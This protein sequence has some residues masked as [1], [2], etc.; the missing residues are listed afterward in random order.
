MKKARFTAAVALALAG[1][2]MAQA[3][4]VY[5]LD[6]RASPNRLLSFPSNA[7][8]NNQVATVAVDSFAMDFDALGTTLYAITPGAAPFNLGTI[9][10]TTGAYTAGPAVTGIA[11]GETP[12]GLKYDPQT[13]GW[14]VSANG[15]AGNRLYTLDVNTGVATFATGITGLAA[16]AILIDIAVDLNG[17]MYGHEIAS[18]SL[19]S[20]NK[21]TGVATTIG[22]TGQAANFAQGMDFDYDTNELFA[23]VYTGGGTGVYAK[24]NLT[25][26]LAQVIT[27]TTPWNSEMEMAVN[28]P[29][30]EPASL[31]LLGL[32]ALLLRRR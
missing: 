25:T 9:N 28:A 17:N 16:G 6:L 30:P 32:G 21:N 3:G 7:P 18:D 14:W 20:I 26:G 29:V 13:N 1:V 5:A 8:A 2:G 19:V 4:T 22:P 23:T 27:S 12:T 15:A 11:A 31:V 24:F 10:T